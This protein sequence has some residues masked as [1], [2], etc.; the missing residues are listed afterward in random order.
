MGR[1]ET[2][3]YPDTAYWRAF[4]GRFSG[5][6]SWDGFDGFWA[7]LAGAPEGWFVFDPRGAAP[8]APLPGEDFATFLGEARTVLEARRGLGHC[9]VVYA[10]DLAAP[11]FVKLFDPTDMGSSCSIGGAPVLPRWVLS[12]IAPDPLPVP[13]PPR[14]G[15]MARVFGR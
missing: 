6:L 8:D 13:E 12:R 11:G 10:D 15:L 5:I 1:A 3:S 9:G 4:R 7:A 14:T 2:F